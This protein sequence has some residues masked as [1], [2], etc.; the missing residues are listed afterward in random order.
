MC[1]YIDDNADSHY[2]A[3]TWF[4]SSFFLLVYIHLHTRLN[5][6]P[7]VFYS[8]F[9]LVFWTAILCRS[10]RII[11]HRPQK[12][13]VFTM[14]NWL[15]S[16]CKH[17]V[18]PSHLLSPRKLWPQITKQFCVCCTTSIRIINAWRK[19]DVMRSIISE[20]WMNLKRRPWWCLQGKLGSICCDQLALLG[21]FPIASVIR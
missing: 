18:W 9:W 2:I 15:S 8:F 11:P 19:N 21:G 6:S 16:W 20:N 5:S 7:M 17:P 14:W 4:A 12:L 13:C 10:T 3:C 1:L